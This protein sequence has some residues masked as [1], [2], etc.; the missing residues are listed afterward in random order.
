MATD[1]SRIAH[2][3]SE[4]DFELLIYLGR[5]VRF[6]AAQGYLM[7]KSGMQYDGSSVIFSLEP[8]YGEVYIGK[9]NVSDGNIKIAEF[10][11]NIRTKL[12]S[13]FGTITDREYT[14]LISEIEIYERD[15][16]DGSLDDHIV[17]MIKSMFSF[18]LVGSPTVVE[19][20]KEILKDTSL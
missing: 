1:T 6:C 19:N 12:D 15:L 14:G 3:D 4:F 8:E 10:L 17:E 9:L 11:K 5:I 20:L 18:E 7:A 2:T 16:K 13:L